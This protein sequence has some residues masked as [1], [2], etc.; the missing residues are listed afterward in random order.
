MS[1]VLTPIRG[2][3]KK[4]E[5]DRNESEGEES[6]AGSAGIAAAKM[7]QRQPT[8]DQQRLRKLTVHPKYSPEPIQP[9]HRSIRRPKQ[10]KQNVLAQEA[11]RRR[12]GDGES[13]ED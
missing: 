6:L 2:G 8:H 1:V 4:R 3:E 9:G 13:Q 11:H 5:E 12:N 7:R 10:V